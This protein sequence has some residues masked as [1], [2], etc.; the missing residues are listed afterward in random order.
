[1]SVESV[2]LSTDRP[3][4]DQLEGHRDFIVASIFPTRAQEQ[5]ESFW[6]VC[7]MV[8]SLEPSK[9]D[10]E[11]FVIFLSGASAV[12]DIGSHKESQEIKGYI[13]EKR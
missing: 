13:Y 4:G 2:C 8:I 9:V 10:V 7:T 6:F 12:V 3:P 5:N 1:M 11:W